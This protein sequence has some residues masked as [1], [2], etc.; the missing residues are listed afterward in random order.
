MDTKA[1]KR[2]AQAD[3]KSDRQK[4]LLKVGAT[5]V[6]AGLAIYGGSKYFGGKHSSDSVKA[7]A[8]VKRGKEAVS[9]NIKSAGNELKRSVKNA[10]GEVWNAG[11]EGVKKGLRDGAKVVGAGMAIYGAQKALEKKYGKQDAEKI[12][13]YGRQ[14]FKK[15]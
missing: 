13:Q 4:K 10:P 15:K 7:R 12:V 3:A 1:A 11:K 8:L 2:Q 6:V 9:R 14:P 5:A